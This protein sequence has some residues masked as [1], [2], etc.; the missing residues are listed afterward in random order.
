MSA[1]APPVV[2]DALA[3]SNKDN[4]AAP[5]TGTA[6]LRHFRFEACFAFDIADTSSLEHIFQNGHGAAIGYALH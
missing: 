6:L 5:S 2:A 3:A 4:P 1:A